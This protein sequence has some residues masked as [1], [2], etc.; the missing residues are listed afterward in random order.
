MPASIV[1]SGAGHCGELDGPRGSST[2]TSRQYDWLSCLLPAVAATFKME[3]C[4][5]PSSMPFINS[6]F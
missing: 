6:N 5:L 2:A 3:G 4:V 1:G